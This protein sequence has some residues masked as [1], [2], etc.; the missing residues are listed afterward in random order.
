M[1]SEIVEPDDTSITEPLRNETDYTLDL[2]GNRLTASVTAYVPNIGYQTRTDTFAY[3]LPTYHA[4]FI[5]SHTNPLSQTESFTYDSRFGTVA[6]HT[7]Y[8]NLVTSSTY[9]TF[10]RVTLTTL[11]DGTK[12]G[13]TYSYCS[14]VNG[15]TATCPTYGAYLAKATP[16]NRRHDPTARSPSATT[17]P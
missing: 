16:C 13:A 11:P 12:T 15:G 9:D 3:D 6:S 4:A 7:D 10:G 8:N 17:I 1:T 5:T 2:Y 14:G